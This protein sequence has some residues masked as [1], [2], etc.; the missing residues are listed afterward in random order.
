MG[1]Y[2]QHANN[3]NP[4]HDTW[5]AFRIF[6]NTDTRAPRGV[7]T[8]IDHS[9]VLLTLPSFHSVKYLWWWSYFSFCSS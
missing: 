6:C 9:S 7:H 4:N 1:K 8:A 5:R 3:G 2:S